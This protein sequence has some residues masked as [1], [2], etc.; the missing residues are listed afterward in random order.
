MSKPVIEEKNKI[1]TVA[2]KNVVE[3]VVKKSACIGQ[4]SL[5]EIKEGDSLYKIARKYTYDI[6]ELLSV[7][8]NEKYRE[9]N[10]FR[11]WDLIYPGE[12]IWLPTSCENNGYND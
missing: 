9:G 7:P 5:Y 12:K 1:E 11:S 10:K 2:V 6:Y 4:Y 3:K 8:G